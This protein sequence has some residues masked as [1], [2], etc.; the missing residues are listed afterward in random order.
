[1][2]ISTSSSSHFP[3]SGSSRARRRRILWQMNALEQILPE[4][5]QHP[6]SS[7]ETIIQDQDLISFDFRSTFAGIEL[8]EKK[9]R[10]KARR[11]KRVQT[12]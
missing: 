12:S 2:P 11:L 4:E 5:E 1:M 6:G 7:I 10:R 3:L 8:E 9:E